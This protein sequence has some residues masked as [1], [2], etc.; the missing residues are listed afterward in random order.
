MNTLPSAEEDESG[1]E[2][3]ATK[4]RA[5]EDSSATFPDNTHSSD[6]PDTSRVTRQGERL[7]AA[8]FYTALTR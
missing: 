3:G 7:R 5:A 1:P 2:P 8:Y 4:P 6:S